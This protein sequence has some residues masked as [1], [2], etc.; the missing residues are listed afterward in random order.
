[1]TAPTADRSPSVVE[2]RS[3]APS[4]LRSTAAPR[5]GSWLA[6][7]VL[8]AGT[9]LI[10]L[11]FFVV[12][13]TIPAL[14]RGL[15]ASPSAIEWVVAGYGLTFAAF[16]VTAGRL[17]DR[18][19]RRRAFSIGLGLFVVASV[20]CGLAPSA[21][22]LIGARLAQGL[23]AALISANVLSIVGVLYEGPRRVTAITVYGM[24]MGVAAAGGQLVGGL[25]IQADIVGTGWRSV[26][27]VN[28]P[29]GLI[30]AAVAPRLVPESRSERAR[31]VDATGMALATLGL[32]ALVL[33]LI[34]GRQQGW[35]AWTWMSLGG[36]AIILGALAAHQRWLAGRGGEPLLDPALLGIATLR[37]GLLTQLLFWCGQAA[38]FLVLA[39]YLQDGRGLDP[40]GS[41][42]VFTVLAASYLA[43][44]LRAPA[45]TARLGRNLIAVGALV[46]AGGDGVLF[47]AVSHQGTGGPVGFLVPG[48]VLIGVGQGLCI[49]PLTA[50]VLSHTDLQ[51]A[52]AV[53]G[54]LS[55]MQQVG[56]ALGVAATGLVFFPALGAGYATAFSRSLL[57][58]GCLALV[59]AALTR[60]LPRPQ[61]RA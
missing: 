12:N 30:A 8:M 48:L 46:L 32:G 45:L 21:P 40:L 61:A 24:V 11:D 60:S 47:T 10:V 37:A 1:M 49:T 51:R 43:A 41:G 16:V 50:T 56:N 52:G 35:P 34:E 20:A 23:G 2:Q 17:G 7:P 6:L 27:L 42:L 28:A 31:R 59:V 15:R 44:S 33:P 14:Q 55:T 9:F 3:G 54:A 29:V 36:A 26:F 25:L 4:S 19:G 38:I 18:V 13:V 39:L 57:Q 22:V 53:S 5:A 58:L